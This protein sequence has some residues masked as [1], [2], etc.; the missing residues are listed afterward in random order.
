MR[1]ESDR[2]GDE[3]YRDQDDPY[4]NEPYETDEYGYDEDDWETGEDESIWRFWDEGIITLLIV[5][6]AILFVFPEPMT[7]AIGVLMLGAGVL[8]WLVDWAT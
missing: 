5:G 7:S 4:E 6:G 8:F 3:T 1:S 2:Y